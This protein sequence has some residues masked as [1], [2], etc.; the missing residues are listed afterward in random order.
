MRCPWCNSG[1]IVLSL[2]ETCG[3]CLECGATWSECDR[4]EP[5][6]IDA[7]DITRQERRRPGVA[8]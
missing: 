4:A 8:A 1:K 6:S 5:L 3:S 2:R 7:P